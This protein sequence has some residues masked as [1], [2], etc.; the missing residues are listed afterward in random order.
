MSLVRISSLP[1]RSRR[2]SRSRKRGSNSFNGQKTTK[3]RNIKSEPVPR[4]DIS[5]KDLIEFLEKLNI[6]KNLK[7]KKEVP[8]LWAEIESRMTSYDAQDPVPARR[9]V[10]APGYGY[11][12]KKSKRC[13]PQYPNDGRTCRGKQNICA[14]R[15]NRSAS[16]SSSVTMYSTEE[17][18]VTLCSE[19]SVSCSA[20][21]SSICS[22]SE[23]E[24]IN[25]PSNNTES[26]RNH[27]N[28]AW[29]NCAT[30]RQGKDRKSP[31]ASSIPRATECFEKSSWNDGADSISAMESEG[32]CEVCRARQLYSQVKSQ[33]CGL[34]CEV[35]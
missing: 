9:Q 12:P 20:A 3:E 4:H 10:S 21:S 18:V 31:V 22:L 23:K 25:H 17:E 5:S 1:P 6:V 19:G 2:S 26:L 13:P 30:L 33:C 32:E 14:H 8:S 35:F 11:Y 24:D 27:I 34:P 15:R 29:S 16:L 28:H 7:C